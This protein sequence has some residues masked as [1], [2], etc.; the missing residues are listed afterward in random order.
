MV[1]CLDVTASGLH[2]RTNGF[3]NASSVAAIDQTTVT[4]EVAAVII[5]FAVDASNGTSI[6]RQ[7]VAT[8]DLD[9]GDFIQTLT[10]VQA[11]GGSTVVT[12]QDVG[13]NLRHKCVVLTRGQHSGT[14]LGRNVLFVQDRSSF[15]E[16]VNDRLSVEGVVST[17]VDHRTAG[18]GTRSG[19]DGVCLACSQSNRTEDLL[20][21]S[22]S[23]SVTDL[24][25]DLA[26]QRV[27]SKG[28][29]EIIQESR[30]NQQV[31]HEDGLL[32][33][34]RITAT[35]DRG[36]RGVVGSFHATSVDELEA[37][38]VT[39]GTVLDSAFSD[40]LGL[41]SLDHLAAEQLQIRGVLSRGATVV[42]ALGQSNSCGV[43]V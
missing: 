23:Q 27:M 11:T 17:Q 43:Q 12:V 1:H 5:V 25:R 4:S 29:I 30:A 36:A 42:V 24:S 21:I 7:V 26:T 33:H 10:A 14:T 6:E 40:R 31:I 8:T 34:R 15:K 22:F 16:S 20:V 3:H 32:S 2:G 38:T 19:S 9:T 41:V 39:Q 28:L 18:L 35:E 13:V 37:L